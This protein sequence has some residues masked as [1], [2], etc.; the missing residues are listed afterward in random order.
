MLPHSSGQSEGYGG[1]DSWGAQT[2]RTQLTG[3]AMERNVAR[4][5]RDRV[6]FSATVAFTQAS[7]LAGVSHSLGMG[8]AKHIAQSGQSSTSHDR[9]VLSLVFVARGVLISMVQYL[10]VYACQHVWITNFTE[11]TFQLQLLLQ[12]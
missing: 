9:R 3:S 6:K 5:F 2:P 8:T 1:G 7:I 4:L 12:C 10:A 11:G